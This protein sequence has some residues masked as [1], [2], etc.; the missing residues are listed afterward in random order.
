MLSYILYYYYL[1]FNV[2]PGLH[3]SSMAS[4]GDGLANPFSREDQLVTFVHVRCALGKF[5][6]LLTD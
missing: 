1:T 4:I 2:I 6:Y 5:V 3:F